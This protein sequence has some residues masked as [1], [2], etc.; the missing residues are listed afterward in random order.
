MEYVFKQVVK[1]VES[2][3][4]KLTYGF[5]SLIYGILIKQKN[6]IIYVEDGVGVS[7]SLLNFSYKLFARKRVPHIVPPNI[8]NIVEYD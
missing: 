8:P 1:H 6:E 4:I 5:P 2:Y 7:P 3:A